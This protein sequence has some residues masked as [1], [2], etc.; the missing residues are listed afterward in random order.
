MSAVPSE[1]EPSCA[2]RGRWFSDGCVHVTGRRC[3]LDTTGPGL[4]SENA[5][6]AALELLASALVADLLAGLGR[7]SARAGVTIHDAEASMSAYLDNPLVALGVVG[8]SGSAAVAS[9]RGSLYVST[10]ADAEAL[11]PLWALVLERASVY[12]TLR[13]CVDVSVELKPMS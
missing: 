2:V 3:V 6:P 13:R 7:E 4:A 9:L 12:A 11:A 5:R 8:E 10:D 1:R